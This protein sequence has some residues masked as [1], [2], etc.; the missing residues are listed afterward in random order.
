MGKDSL[1]EEDMKIIKFSALCICLSVM[2]FGC[3]N[4][5]IQKKPIYQKATE[6]KTLVNQQEWDKAKEGSKDIYQLYKENKWKYQFLGDETEY[7]TLNQ[8]IQKLIISIEE[9][10][11]KEA[12]FNLA[13]IEHYME[14]L[15]FK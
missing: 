4:E 6:I 3:S 13:M 14:S 8:H 12:K 11:T 5:T 10:D 2:L 1:L 7:N 15:Y 9:Q